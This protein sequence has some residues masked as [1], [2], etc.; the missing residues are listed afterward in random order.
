VRSGARGPPPNTPSTAAHRSGATGPVDIGALSSL[1]ALPFFGPIAAS[2]AAPA[3][4]G[5]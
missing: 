1:V 2:D 4:F 3:S 5:R